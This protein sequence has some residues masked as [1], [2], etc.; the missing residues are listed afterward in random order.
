M[1]VSRTMLYRKMFRMFDKNED[2]TASKQEV[3]DG[4][5]SVCPRAHGITCKV[6][7]GVESVCPRAR[8]I[9][10]TVLDGLESV[11]PRVRGITCIIHR[12]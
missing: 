3:L 1:V 4:L 5:E 12:V 10:C 11:C 9:T 8:G 2:G 6:L 7:D